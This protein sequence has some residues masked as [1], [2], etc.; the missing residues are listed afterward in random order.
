M[1][2]DVRVNVA[3]VSIRKL[4]NLLRVTHSGKTSSQVTHPVVFTKNVFKS[5]ASR[6]QRSYEDLRS[7]SAA[8]SLAIDAPLLYNE[9]VLAWIVVVD[10]A[11]RVGP[12]P[13]CKTR[14]SVTSH[15]SISVGQRTGV[16]TKNGAVG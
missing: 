5:P 13:L 6:L 1:S 3:I 11:I 14:R 2:L 10:R 15:V 12:P 16:N 9:F 8:T 4:S 7:H